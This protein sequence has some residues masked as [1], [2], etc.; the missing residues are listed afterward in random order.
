M[1]LCL[2]RTV[3]NDIRS[4]HLPLSRQSNS[5]TMQPTFL[6]HGTTPNVSDSRWMIWCRILGAYQNMAGADPA[7]NPHLSD[8]IW[9]LKHKINK[10]LGI[11]S[12]S[13]CTEPAAPTNLQAFAFTD[14]AETV[15]SYIGFPLLDFIIKYGTVQGGPYPNQTASGAIPPGSSGYELTGL[16]LLTTYYAVIIARDS[17]SCVSEPS[18]EV[19]FTTI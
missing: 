6:A 1:R 9:T 8:T 11:I 14:A 10:A 12:G 3:W 15:W 18:S 19:T 5:Q 2:G 4:I 16:S 7:N 13:I 17:E